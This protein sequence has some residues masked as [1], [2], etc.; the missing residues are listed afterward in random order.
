MCKYFFK[1]TYITDILHL[2]TESCD[3]YFRSNEKAR[4]TK[5]FLKTKT[6]Y[7]DKCE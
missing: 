1:N 3:T 5:Y 4:N 6:K 7:T 2:T